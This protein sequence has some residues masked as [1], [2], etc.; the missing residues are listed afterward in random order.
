[1][2]PGCLFDYGMNHCNDNNL[3]PDDWFVED[4]YKNRFK[5]YK[6]TINNLPP[7]AVAYS[8]E[9]HNLDEAGG[10]LVVVHADEQPNF[11]IDQVICNNHPRVTT[12]TL[13]NQSEWDAFFINGDN[14]T[15]NI[16]IGFYFSSF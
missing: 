6:L 12:D 15:S 1:M 13:H 7:A 16:V 4:Q 3:G 9:F 8:W 2:A 5:H 10:R 14:V 11:N